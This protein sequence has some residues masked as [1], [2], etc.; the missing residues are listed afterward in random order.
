M[1]ES[2]YMEQ[3]QEQMYQEWLKENED[4]A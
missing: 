3:E 2:Y 4:R 1:N